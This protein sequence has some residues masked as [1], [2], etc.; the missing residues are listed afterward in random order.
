MVGGDTVLSSQV[1]QGLW[2]DC[3]VDEGDSA[4]VYIEDLK[5]SH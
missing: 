1:A 5:N 4:N 3:Q 2:P